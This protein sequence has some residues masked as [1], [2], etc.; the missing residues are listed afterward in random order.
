MRELWG[1]RGR[2]EAF[3]APTQLIRGWLEEIRHL[4]RGLRG[5]EQPGRRRSRET[6]HFAGHM[7]LI[8]VTCLC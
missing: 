1:F 4:Q 6:L 7:G 5:L 8:A 3:I 2:T